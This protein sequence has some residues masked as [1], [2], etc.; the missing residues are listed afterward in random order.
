MS[1]PMTFMPSFFTNIAILV[2]TITTLRMQ[3]DQIVQDPTL[4][5][6]YFAY[7]P[8]TTPGVPAAVPPRTDINAADVNAAQSSLQQLFFTLDSG[9]PPQKNALYQVMP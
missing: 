9:T 4:I 7:V 6:D 8:P 3:Y 5:T 1:N 2:N